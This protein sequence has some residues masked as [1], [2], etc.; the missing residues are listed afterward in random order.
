MR[1]GEKARPVASARPAGRRGPGDRRTGAMG[2]VRPAPGEARR[3]AG[4]EGGEG[5]PLGFASG[6]VALGEVGGGHASG[7]GFGERMA[8]SEGREKTA[9]LGKI[10]HGPP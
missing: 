3:V 2:I 7:Q 4:E 8:V 1:G 10:F 9:R 5:Q 6:T